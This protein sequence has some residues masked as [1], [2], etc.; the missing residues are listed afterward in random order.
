MAHLSIKERQEQFIFLV[1]LSVFTTGLLSWLLFNGNDL[2]TAAIKE[3]LAQK[4][5]EEQQFE[6]MVTEMK[7]AIDTTYKKIMDFDPTVQALFLESD[8]LN[9][10]ASIKAAYQRRSYDVRYKAFLEAA[11]LLETLFYDKKELRGN[12]RNIEKLNAD[13]ER[14]RLSR[15]N[16]QDALLNNNRNR[17]S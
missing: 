3:K 7:P 6:A 14:C 8:I 11:Q 13:L 15:R 4:V 5:K 12:N 17:P 16:L 9:S 10:I 2:K 1:I